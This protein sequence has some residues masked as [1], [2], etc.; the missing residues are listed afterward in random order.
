MPSSGSIW[1]LLLG[2]MSTTLY[3]KGGMDITA[4]V[5]IE[6]LRLDA[7]SMKK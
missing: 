1:L 2:V 5:L 6:L 3:F 4:E 7:D